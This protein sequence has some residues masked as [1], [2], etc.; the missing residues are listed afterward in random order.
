LLLLFECHDL[1]SFL[2]SYFFLSFFFFFIYYYY[3]Y[4]Y[5]DLGPTSTMS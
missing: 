4:Y 5:Y 3:Y 1:L 2:R